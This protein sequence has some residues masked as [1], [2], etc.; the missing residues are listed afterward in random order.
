MTKAKYFRA[1]DNSS[2]EKVYGEIDQL[3]KTKIEELTFYQYEEHFYWL[4][5]GALIVLALEW[6]L[7]L[8]IYR[9]FI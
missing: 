7:R 4:A 2:L 6:L 9:S 3:E 8:T 1:T 5:F